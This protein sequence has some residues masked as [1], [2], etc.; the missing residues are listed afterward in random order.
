MHII[1]KHP[2]DQKTMSMIVHIEYDEFVYFNQTSWNI[3]YIMNY[4]NVNI[5]QGIW[6]TFYKGSIIV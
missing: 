6:C 2:F 4:R 1:N 3:N 5:T